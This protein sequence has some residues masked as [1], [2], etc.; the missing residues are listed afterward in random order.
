LFTVAGE[1]K[2]LDVASGASPAVVA[3]ADSGAGA[4][5]NRDGVVLLGSF[6][7]ALQAGSASGG[8][9]RT[10]TALDRQRLEVAHS[11]PKF[12]PDG[13]HFLY[14]ARSEVP[15]ESA[16][17][18]SSLDGKVRK[19]LLPSEAPAQFVPAR[20]DGRSHAGYLLYVHDRNLVAH[21]FDSETL[22]VTGDYQRID[23]DLSVFTYG[24]TSLSASSTGVIVYSK[25]PGVSGELKWVDRNGTVA[26][27]LGTPGSLG[28]PVISPDGKFVAFD[29][30]E[31]SNRDIWTIEI[32]TGKLMRLTF[33]PEIDHC[34]VWSPD[35]AQVAF[36]SHRSSSGVYVK[37]SRGAGAEWLLA[38]GGFSAAWTPDGRFVVS[39]SMQ[40]I[41]DPGGI[42]LLPIDRPGAATRWIHSE[43]NERHLAVS[44][45]GRWIAYTA[46]ESG[47]DNIFVRRF[48]PFSPSSRDKRQISVDG[49]SQP[50]WRGDGKEL[51]FLSRENVV[52]AAAVT[53]GQTFDNQRPVA[54]FDTGVK[55]LRGPCRDYDTRDGQ[56]FVVRAP[57]QRTPGPPLHVLLNW[58]SMLNE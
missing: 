3:R 49:G 45:D 48:D 57:A 20:Q 37:D 50:V 53:T 38:K 11:F 9:F 26:G 32:A 15:H 36:E 4:D 19:R 39:T 41:Q 22:E 25:D 29:R 13:K 8:P 52:M 12:L 16:I 31:E 33:D 7:G 10:A 24:Q 17:F 43:N 1:L 28:D 34:P 23:G 51:F 47:Q 2:K 42:W 35:G 44:P 54:L 58:Q 18:V 40:P 6:T 46:N 21:P 27:V 56:R 30:A 5:C 55:F 14:L